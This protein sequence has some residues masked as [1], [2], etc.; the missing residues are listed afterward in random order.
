MFGTEFNGPDVN[1][2]V[3]ADRASYMR[4]LAES[5]VFNNSDVVNPKEKDDDDPEAPEQGDLPT[6]GWYIG[7][8]KM[9][10]ASAGVYTATIAATAGDEWTIATPSGVYGPATDGQST[11]AGELA[12]AAETSA[13]FGYTGTYSV[14]VVDKGN[15]VVEYSL[16]CNNASLR[17]GNNFDNNNTQLSYASSTYDFV[18]IAD[19]TYKVSF[20]TTRGKY[21]GIYTVENKKY[22]I[23]NGTPV[24]EGELT[25]AASEGSARFPLAGEFYVIATLIDAGT[26][27]VKL[28]VAKDIN[29]ALFRLTGSF[30]SDAGYNDS[31]SYEFKNVSANTYELTIDAEAGT[32]WK[33]HS[34]PFAIFAHMNDGSAETSGELHTKWNG[35]G[36][37]AEAGKYKITLKIGVGAAPF[38]TYEC[39]KAE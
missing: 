32:T 26:I 7:D 37:M 20:K 21:W 14:K 4:D 23:A 33:V 39:V 3:A 17:L 1:C 12:L 27:A 28:E 10:E 13:K 6:D 22:G 11:F 16:V 24:L 19:N 31:A 5:I 36:K 34:S 2:N 18:N 8:V 29:D 30:S 38:L 35:Y 25:R 9:D 15:G